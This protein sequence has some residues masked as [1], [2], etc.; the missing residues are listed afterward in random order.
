[1]IYA[2]IRNRTVLMVEKRLASLPYTDDLTPLIESKYFVGSL[3]PYFKPV[4]EAQWNSIR[5][6]WI[7]NEKDG[8]QEPSPFSVNP[9]SGELY[10]PES[11][12]AAD[13]HETM[14]QSAQVPVLL[15]AVDKQK[16]QTEAANAELSR[17]IASCQA[18]NDKA[19]AELSILIGGNENV[20]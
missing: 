5:P 7:W 14:N 10:L 16:A 3:I 15:E 19:V 18:Q 1:M 9:E 6:G 4:P 8:F 13:F 11:V 12:S 17:L 2:Y 20:S